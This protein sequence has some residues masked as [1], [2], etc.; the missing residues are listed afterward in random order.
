MP[1]YRIELVWT[2]AERDEEL[3]FLRKEQA[4]FLRHVLQG[5]VDAD[6]LGGFSL[7]EWEPSSF[8]DVMDW[9][10]ANKVVSPKDWAPRKRPD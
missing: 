7:D 2:E 3:V 8:D 5:A 1:I 6:K 4:V 10:K 9:L